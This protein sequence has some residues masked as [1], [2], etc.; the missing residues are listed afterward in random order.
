M[1]PLRR[2]NKPLCC[3]S[4]K[5]RHRWVDAGRR[6]YSTLPKFGF[7]VFLRHLIPVRG[8]YRDRHET[9]DG[10]WRTL[11]A[12]ARRASQGGKTVSDSGAQRPVR[13]AYGKTVS[14]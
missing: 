3:P 10:L 2:N 7:G 14:S 1:T 6:K 5:S 11:A 4:G 13:F 12:L 8:A 9:R